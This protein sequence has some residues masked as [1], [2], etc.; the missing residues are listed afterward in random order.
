[1]AAVEVFNFQ[2]WWICGRKRQYTF[3]SQAVSRAH[4]AS[5]PLVAYHCPFGE[6]WHVGRKANPLGATS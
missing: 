3:E 5:V 4:D 1:M 6:H 2:R